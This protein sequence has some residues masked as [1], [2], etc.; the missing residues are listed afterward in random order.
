MFVCLSAK[1]LN[2][3]LTIVARAL[4]DET[5]DKLYRAGADHVVSPNVSAPDSRL[6]G[7]TLLD[8]RIPQQT[9]LLVNAPRKLQDEKHRFV[10]NPAADT[11]LEPGDELIVMGKPE[12]IAQLRDYVKA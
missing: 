3:D 1:D 9:G 6:A 2:P 5:V 8:A 7:L 12:Q 10:F 4:K 11:R